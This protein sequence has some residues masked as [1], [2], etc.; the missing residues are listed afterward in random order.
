MNARITCPLPV[1]FFGNASRGNKFDRK[2]AFQ[3]ASVTHWTH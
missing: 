2:G 3:C 1:S